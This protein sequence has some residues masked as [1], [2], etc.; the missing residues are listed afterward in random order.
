[1]DSFDSAGVEQDSLT[2]GCL[3]TVDVCLERGGI[4]SAE[5][6]LRAARDKSYSNT[7]VANP[8]E[9]FGLFGVHV[10]GDVFGGQTSSILLGFLETKEK[11]SAQIDH[12]GIF[13]NSRLQRSIASPLG[14]AKSSSTLPDGSSW[15]NVERTATAADVLGAKV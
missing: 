2:D 12:R 7:N 9:T 11:L 4:V 3:A 13:T 8:G 15:S 5:A 10:G 14:L 6:R 1:M